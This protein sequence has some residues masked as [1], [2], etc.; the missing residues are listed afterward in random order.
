MKQPVI[1][2]IFKDLLVKGKTTEQISLE[3]WEM[4]GN[5]PNLKCMSFC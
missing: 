1:T 4:L 5:L 2:F 3:F